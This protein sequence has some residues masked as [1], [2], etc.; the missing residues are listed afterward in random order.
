MDDVPLPEPT[1]SVLHEDAAAAQQK[2]R[3]FAFRRKPVSSP[4]PRSLICQGQPLG[5]QRGCAAWCIH[6]REYALCVMRL[7]LALPACMHEHIC[8]CDMSCL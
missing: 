3:R 5:V 8:T 2:H 7:L 1:Y 6:V 4:H